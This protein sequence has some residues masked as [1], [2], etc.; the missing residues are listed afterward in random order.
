MNFVK[1]DYFLFVDLIV[2]FGINNSF[3]YFLI[4][5]GI[6]YYS[7][8]HNSHHNETHKQYDYLLKLPK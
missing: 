8:Y 1:L 2:V 5:Q 3:N 4:L 6:N 7:F